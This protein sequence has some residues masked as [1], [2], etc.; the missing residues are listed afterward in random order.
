MYSMGENIGISPEIMKSMIKEIDVNGDGT[1][2]INEWITFISKTRRQDKLVVRGKDN[3]N[4]LL[5]FL[6]MNKGNGISMKRKMNFN[7][8]D[9]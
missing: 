8:H 2:E 4:I 9:D 5:D 3:N 7:L 1:I 6:D